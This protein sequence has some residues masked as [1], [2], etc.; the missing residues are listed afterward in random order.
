MKRSMLFTTVIILITF[1]SACGISPDEVS[2]LPS[3]IPEFDDSKQEKS[4]EPTD[5]A[6][7]AVTKQLSD[8]ELSTP[9]IYEL[10][11]N[12]NYLIDLDNKGE[13]A[14]LSITDTSYRYDIILNN[15]PA[16]RLHYGDLYLTLNETD[17]EKTGIVFEYS[18]KLIR[19]YS[20]SVGLILSGKTA[21]GN[22]VTYLYHIVGSKAILRQHFNYTL[23]DLTID[24]LRLHGSFDFPRIE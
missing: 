20:G 6:A 3:Y 14:L 22:H 13:R 15:K 10:E 11:A 18:V 19:K 8:Q 4:S 12:H 24:S 2:V 1:L 7:P 16:T 5:E 9:G 21:T 23:S 17:Y